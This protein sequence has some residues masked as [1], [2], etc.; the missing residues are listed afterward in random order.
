[1]EGWG[2]RGRHRAGRE[3]K[4]FRENAASECCYETANKGYQLLTILRSSSV[5]NLP[6]VRKL[7]SACFKAIVNLQESQDITQRGC[8]QLF[9]FAYLSLFS[10][11]FCLQKTGEN[12]LLL[13]HSC[14]FIGFIQSVCKQWWR[15]MDTASPKYS[16]GCHHHFK[17]LCVL[18]RRYK[19][20]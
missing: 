18:G 9:C 15:T 4:W 2:R 5:Y 11:S 14:G 10:G 3:I 20:I 7:R 6:H 1:M 19:S 12:L 17:V 13:R 8:P 16:L